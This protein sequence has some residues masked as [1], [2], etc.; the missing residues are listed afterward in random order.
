MNSGYGEFMTREVR[1]PNTVFQ[2]CWVCF[3]FFFFFVFFN[4]CSF[5][6]K[7]NLPEMQLWAWHE[8]GLWCYRCGWWF[9]GWFCLRRFCLH[10][11]SS[12]VWIQTILFTYGYGLW[13]SGLE[14]ACHVWE[15]QI[16][17]GRAVAFT[18]V[19]LYNMYS[20]KTSHMVTWKKGSEIPHVDM[21]K[22]IK[23]T[24]LLSV[25]TFV[26]HP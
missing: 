1:H 15:K 24:H 11:H 14:L 4:L 19:T 23:A 26:L 21:K 3:S 13:G 22:I 8:S 9:W 25:S 6:T 16:A 12:V 5:K 18:S 2:V 20:W 7:I 10:V 17:F